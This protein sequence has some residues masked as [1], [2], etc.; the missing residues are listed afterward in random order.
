MKRQKANTKI[1]QNTS[2]NRR[3]I[4]THE[5][6]ERTMGK[7][8]PLI[9]SGLKDLIAKTGPIWP[10]STKLAGFGSSGPYHCADCEYLNKDGNRCDHPVML[11]DS[12]VPHDEKGLAIITD[13]AHQ[14]CEFVEPKN[15][16]KVETLSQPKLVALFMRH[17]QTLANARNEFR[18][19]LNVLL[20]SVGKQQAIEGRG[21]L[22]SYL[23]TQPLGEAFRSSKDRTKQTADIVLGPGRAKVVKNFDSLN[24][25]KFAGQEKTPE[26]IK[27]IEYYQ[28]HPEEKI[29]G[30][31]RINDFRKRTDPEIMAAVHSIDKTG[32]P[33]I[34]FV[35][36]S[37]IHEVSHLFHG[38]H[39]AVKVSPGGFVAVF[40]RPNGTYFAQALLRES[41]GKK[42][43]QLVS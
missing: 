30:G 17:G 33:S 18:G 36:S 41:E 8:W 15:V 21:F 31:E 35:H 32:R 42:D 13:A 16:V 25:G 14:C 4:V 7:N 5:R 28:V 2:I 40:K 34:S 43:R 38:D 26:N 37:T 12:E 10:K 24:V 19:P 39:N 3:H 11:A 22:A 1:Y 29:P 20:D 27:K 23:G 9:I 6:R